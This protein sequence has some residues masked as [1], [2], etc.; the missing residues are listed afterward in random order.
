MEN[1]ATFEDSGYVW[2]KMDEESVHRIDG[3]MPFK[4]RAEDSGNQLM[5][6]T[7]GGWRDDT[8]ETSPTFDASCKR[9]LIALVGPPPWEN[10]KCSIVSAPSQTP[11]DRIAALGKNLGV[12]SRM[13][14]SE[15]AELSRIAIGL[16]DERSEMLS[17]IDHAVADSH[18]KRARNA[19][20]K[21]ERDALKAVNER[22]RS[23]PKV[24]IEGKGSIT[25]DGSI[26]AQAV[27]ALATERDSLRAEC[28]RLRVKMQSIIARR[29]HLESK[30]AAIREA[31]EEAESGAGSVP[32]EETIR[33]A[34]EVF[35][36]IFADAE[37]GVM[38][39]A[40][41]DC[42]HGEPMHDHGDGCPSCSQEPNDDE[43][44]PSATM[45]E[46]SRMREYMQGMEVGP[47][48]EA[49]VLNM[50]NE[51]FARVKAN[52]GFDRIMTDDRVREIC[53]EEIDRRFPPVGAISVGLQKSLAQLF[54]EAAATARKQVS[55]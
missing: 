24:I 21:A 14:E 29:D 11:R 13:A 42:P 8:D 1:K 10:P 33:A 48:T 20:L 28:A 7:C 55:T 41:L 32:R 30:L 44:V 53:R 5:M 3:G 34:A 52:G 40:V 35:R 9:A 31:A 2:E 4:W 16:A 6:R 22:L 26:G 25:L 51:A 18:S 47:A 36:V 54:E 15:F 39:P 43:P 37:Y 23:Q 17:K 45:D 27:A 12:L 19:E 38:L 46:W 50:V 49:R